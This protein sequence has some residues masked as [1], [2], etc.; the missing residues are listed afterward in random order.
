MTRRRQDPDFDREEIEGDDPLGEQAF[1]E[2]GFQDAP[3][4][5]PDFSAPGLDDAPDKRPARGGQKVAGIPESRQHEV[6]TPS[7]QRP[8]TSRGVIKERGGEGKG[9]PAV[10]G[11]RPD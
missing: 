7:E 5:G 2:A 11:T 1:A 10:G 9:D 4:G 8:D 3:G 6:N